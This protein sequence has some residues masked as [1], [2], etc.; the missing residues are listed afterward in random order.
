[1]NRKLRPLRPL[2][3]IYYI[4]FQLGQLANI[5]I[6]ETQSRQYLKMG[7]PYAF[8][9]Y[10][11]IIHKY[12]RINV[13]EE[14]Y[15]IVLDFQTQ[16]DDLIQHYRGLRSTLASFIESQWFQQLLHSVHI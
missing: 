9:Q 2:E 13:R 15:L 4:L 12:I 11:K 1:M 10:R 8:Q 3:I 5:L 7:M 6:A 16:L 14:I